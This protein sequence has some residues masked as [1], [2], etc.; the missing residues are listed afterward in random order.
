MER[1]RRDM[2]TRFGNLTDGFFKNFVKNMGK[3]ATW[4]IAGTLIY[5]S[6]NIIKEGISYLSD[7]DNSLNQI[8]IV[9]GNTQI[10]V[11]KLADSYNDLAKE[12]SVTTKEIAGTA[13][14]LFRQGLDNSQVEERMKGI[15]EYA[16]ISSITLQQSDKIITA[17]ANATGESVQKIIDIFALLGDTTA[18]GAEEI[19]ESLQRVASAAENS[20]IS[21]EKSAS[22][23]ATI[24]SITRES[25][26]TIG[27]SI[28]SIISR[29]ES[30]KKT[31][32]NSEDSTSL[33]DV[34]KALSQIGITAT[35]SQGQLR[36][37]A[38]VMDEVGAR[39]NTLSKNEKAY[40]A[41]TMFGK[42]CHFIQ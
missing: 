22:W 18:S 37:F 31:G 3:M 9:T 11:E 36:D 25:A 14:S 35:D 30:I 15:I 20:N 4:G 24:S 34:T 26:S 42:I 27:R 1:T 33:N 16:K 13:A 41:T 17:T 10:E 21:L 5:G 19:G 38:D 28:N 40:I 7:L 6:L 32:F 12:M 8:R 29:Y 39:F 23:L 2:Q